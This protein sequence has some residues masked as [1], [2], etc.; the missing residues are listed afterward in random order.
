MDSE[1]EL[2]DIIQEM[3]NYKHLILLIHVIDH[4][5]VCFY[6]QDVI[7]TRPDFY[8][9]ILDSNCIQQLLGLLGHENI[10]KILK[11]YCKNY[12]FA[13]LKSH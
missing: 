10:G 11:I 6:F 2:N 8:P 3:R 9:I 1:V 13:L 5:K 12:E 4:F 7:S